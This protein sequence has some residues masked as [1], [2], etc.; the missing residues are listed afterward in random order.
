MAFG[1]WQ[2]KVRGPFL[3]NDEAQKKAVQFVARMLQG[4]AE[5]PGEEIVPPFHFDRQFLAGQPKSLEAKGV[6]ISVPVLVRNGDSPDPIIVSCHDKWGHMTAPLFQEEWS[7]IARGPYAH[8]MTGAGVIPTGT[9][10]LK[11][12]RFEFDDDDAGLDLAGHDI[13]IELVV[14]TQRTRAAVDKG[15]LSAIEPLVITFKVIPTNL[16][17][18]LK[19]L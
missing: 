17:C 6:N 1:D 9:A 14:V 13:D 18:V 11:F 16:P 3:S 7:V 2:I 19:V 10:E 5:E 8:L 4:S 12:E 15:D